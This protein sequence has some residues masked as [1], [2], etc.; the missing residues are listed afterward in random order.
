MDLQTVLED[1]KVDAVFVCTPHHLHLP[2]SQ[3]AVD[4]G[5]HVIVENRQTIWIRHAKCMRL[6]KI[7]VRVRQWLLY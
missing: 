1:K 6:Y 5:K 7:P 2:V 4:L 3:S